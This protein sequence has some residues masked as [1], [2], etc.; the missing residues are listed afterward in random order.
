MLTGEYKID[1]SIFRD[2]DI[3]GIYPGEVNEK[4]FYAIGRA[5]TV[6][7][8]AGN[9]SVGRDIR[10]SSEKLARSFISGITDQ[11]ADVIDLGLI[12]TEMNYFASGKYGFDVSAIVS[13]S[14]N[15]PQSNGLKIVRKGVVPLHGHFG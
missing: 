11:G 13:A 1:E 12:S 10:L 14:H 2:Y 8:Q 5:L 4:T 15:P 9:I 3:R 6:Y 7:T